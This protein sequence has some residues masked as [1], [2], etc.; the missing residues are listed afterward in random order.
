MADHLNDDERRRRDD[1]ERRRWNEALELRNQH[2]RELAWK[3][4]KSPS[5]RRLAE[6]YRSSPGYGE[7]G[8]TVIPDH[9][10]DPNEE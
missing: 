4:Y 7:E 1:E 5:R 3:R 6:R 9:P 8:G 10:Y 2:E